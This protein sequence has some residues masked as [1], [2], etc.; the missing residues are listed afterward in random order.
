MNN[1]TQAVRTT[2]L[3]ALILIGATF[4]SANYEEN[5]REGIF[6]VRPDSEHLANHDFPT[7]LENEDLTFFACIEQQD[8]PIRLSFLCED[9]NE[10]ADVQ[11][12]KWGPDNCYIGSINLEQF[13]CSQATVRADYTRTGQNEN[14]QQEIRINKFN[15]ALDKIVETQFSDG[16]WQGA[17]DTAY[18]IFVISQFPDL[19]REN[20]DQ[21]I[22]YLKVNRDEQDR[23]WP[24]RNCQT[25]TTANILYLLERAGFEDLRIQRD[26]E[27]Y[28][29]REQVYFS[30]QTQWNAQI[31]D[32]TININNSA[33]TSCVYDYDQAVE[34]FSLDRHPESTTKTLTPNHNKN[35]S[36]VCTEPV[37][38]DLQNEFDETIISYQGTN[39]TYEIPPSCWT[40]GNERINCDVKTT[41]YALQTSIDTNQKT[42][43][44][45]YLSTLLVP[46]RTAGYHLGE[47][48]TT[49]MNSLYVQAAAPD[50]S[51][52]LQSLLYYQANNG[53]WANPRIYYP[54]T[55]FEATQE[56][57]NR[58][59]H[60]INDTITH[61]IIQT[62]YA[63][64][65]LIDQGAENYREE[66]NDAQR[67]I[68]LIEDQTSLNISDE[69]LTD[70]EA[71]EEYEAKVAEILSDPKRNAMAFYVLQEN[72]RPIIR[73]EPRILLLDRQTTTIDLINP[74]IFELEELEYELSDN[75]RPI[76]ELEEKDY[77]AGYSFRRIA[78]E[79]T[80]DS[81][82]EFGYLR[83]KINDNEYL[84]LPIITTQK[85]ELEITLP[86]QMTVFGASTTLPFEVHKS[87]HEFDCS[88]EW[89]TEGI[90]STSGFN[91]QN[92]RN[93]TYNYPV[94][95]SAT[96]TE[97]KVYE[98]TITCQV[99][100][101]TFVNEFATNIA[102]FANRPLEVRP[103]TISVT[104]REEYQL[105][106]RNLLDTSIEVQVSL[107][108]SEP[109][110]VISNQ[111]LNLFPGETT[112]IT[113]QYV[114]EADQNYTGTNS[115]V[116]STFNVEER[117]LITTDIQEILETTIGI[118][119]WIAVAFFLS[120]LA[121][122]GYFA[123]T[124]RE[125][126]KDWYEKRFKK[127]DI[128]ATI[129]AQVTQIEREEQQEAIRNMK[130]IAKLQGKKDTEI[131]DLL[132]QQGYTQEDIE[133]ALS[134]NT[135]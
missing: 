108:D 18:G 123:Y 134:A 27:L 17:L 87:E 54:H 102:R 15:K 73:T 90:S 77:I 133:E 112:N 96:E 44:R 71:V 74:T 105:Q 116:F 34:T 89:D 63:V 118:W 50:A 119:L 69:E 88:L 114:A 135:Q 11:A 126:I 125:Q 79:L 101:V 47:N 16:G 22:E 84:K 97:N 113:L 37:F 35:L 30:S 86:E 45:N 107:R 61:Q 129:Q 76:I 33:D 5:I 25:S 127:E 8:T 23:C 56:E 93:G 13:D 130:R 52:V 10:F 103:A 20:I 31:T 60:R 14:L 62:G 104:D 109:I 98:G 42:A 4:V 36:I 81:A 92:T 117:V 122:L 32:H 28:L 99:G 111:L 57:R 100:S 12:Y 55:Y 43:A 68:S 51:S 72:A 48:H 94:R 75:L 78:I 67:F 40:L 82:E 24:N 58:I 29:Q 1:T 85:P 6:L 3:V 95:F 65:A 53:S 19:F 46:D 59:P 128:A 49:I 91:I 64:M 66:I 38:I 26:A 70:Q 83:L 39:F 120:S 124:R 7:Y 2:I 131:N 132:K 21:A 106:V 80:D 41:L 110:A 115:L 9:T 121:V